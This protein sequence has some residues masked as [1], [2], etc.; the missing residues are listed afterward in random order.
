MERVLKGIHLNFLTWCLYIFQTITNKWP[1]HLYFRNFNDRKLTLAG[2]V[3]TT[4]RKAF[5]TFV[6]FVLHSQNS[7]KTKNSSSKPKLTYFN[8]F[9]KDISEVQVI[10]Y[11]YMWNAYFAESLRQA[12]RNHQIRCRGNGEEKS[13]SD[14]QICSG[15]LHASTAPSQEAH[16]TVIFNRDLNLFKF[17]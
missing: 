6:C 9:I 2:G 3:K 16:Q 13:R 12:I 10:D 5:L 11:L 1:S 14:L 15:V 7:T 4:L 17:I 8:P